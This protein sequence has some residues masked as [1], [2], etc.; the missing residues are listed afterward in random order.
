[1]RK[2]YYYYYKV[3]LILTV[4]TAIIFISLIH[5]N[6]TQDE[7]VGYK[8]KFSMFLQQMLITNAVTTS[9]RRVVSYDYSRVPL[10]GQMHCRVFCPKLGL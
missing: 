4:I 3:R 5:N 2:C 8:Y 1:M 10:W 9:Q 7:N 6:I